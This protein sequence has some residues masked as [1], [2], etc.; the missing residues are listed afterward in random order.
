[1]CL[2]L[3]KF[4]IIIVIFSSCFLIGCSNDPPPEK[5]A[6]KI[7]M[8]SSVLDEDK[9]VYRFIREFIDQKGDDV[10]PIG[11]NVERKPDNKYLV[12]YKY[13]LYSFNEGIGEK[14]FFFEVD[15]DN[16]SVTDRTKEYLEKMKPLSNAYKSEKELFKEIVNGEDSTMVEP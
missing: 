5:R 10:K 4:F 7:V 1:M 14:G 13:K 16:E 3:K 8:D 9:S 11:W 15:L 2:F 12:S 6:L